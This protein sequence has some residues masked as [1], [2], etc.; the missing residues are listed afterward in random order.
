MESNTHDSPAAQAF[1]LIPYELVLSPVTKPAVVAAFALIGLYLGKND[2][3][4]ALDTLRCKDKKP[5]A[6]DVK[7]LRAARLALVDEGLLKMERKAGK[8]TWSFQ[9]VANIDR[10]TAIRLPRKAIETLNAAE[11]FVLALIYHYDRGT[12]Q[13]CSRPRVDLQA[14]RWKTRQMR[15]IL[16]AL[17][18]NGFIIKAPFVGMKD[19]WRYAVTYNRTHEEIT[20]FLAWTREPAGQISPGSDPTNRQN[21]TG[22]TGNKSPDGAAINHRVTKA[23]L[24]GRVPLKTVPAEIEGGAVH[25]PPWT[26]HNILAC[27]VGYFRVEGIDIKRLNSAK[28]RRQI[29]DIYLELGYSFDEIPKLIKAT[30]G[31][32]LLYALALYRDNYVEHNRLRDQMPHIEE[33]SVQPRKPGALLKTMLRSIAASNWHD[34]PAIGKLSDAWHDHHGFE[35]V[36]Q[37]PPTGCNPEW[38]VPQVTRWRAPQGKDPTTLLMEAIL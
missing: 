19:R 33:P 9:L 26:Q 8:R 36:S 13:G 16:T 15:N 38:R 3:F 11:L 21:I 27:G 12:A 22:S 31:E 7:I 37:L 4:A 6:M 2:C 24:L 17:E 5:R 14:G 20:A 35:A 29:G 32:V 30:Q 10:K 1:S 28:V 18:R 34:L 25:D 23:P